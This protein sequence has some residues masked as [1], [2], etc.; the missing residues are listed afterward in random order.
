METQCLSVKVVK[1]K[2]ATLRGMRA[3]TRG[4]A[5]RKKPSKRNDF[6]PFIG[7][8]AQTPKRSITTAPI[9]TQKYAIKL[10]DF[11][12]RRITTFF[13]LPNPRN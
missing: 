9:S 2:I 5:K 4:N 11:K 12:K 13:K 8:E 10:K 6:H 1:A 7:M 3:R